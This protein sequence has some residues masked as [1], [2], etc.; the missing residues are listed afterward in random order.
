MLSNWLKTITVCNCWQANIELKISLPFPTYWLLI[1]W[2]HLSYRKKN[3]VIDIYN[4]EGI[5]EK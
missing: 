5:R 1:G 3:V 2:Y 4:K